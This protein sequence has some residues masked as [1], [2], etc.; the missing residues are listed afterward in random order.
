[1]KPRLK[2]VWQ[3]FGQP[4]IRILIQDRLPIA[5]SSY[6]SSNKISELTFQRVGEESV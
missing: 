5:V 2:A 4:P 3:E 1:M 6:E